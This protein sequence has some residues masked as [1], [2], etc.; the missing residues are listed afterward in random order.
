MTV[1]REGRHPGEFLLSEAAGQRSRGTATIA[2][3]AGVIAAGTVLG[4]DGANYVPATDATDAVAVSI[5]GC[6]A[7]VEDQDIAIIARDAEVKA[8]ALTF[9]ASVDD[10]TKRAAKVTQLA[11]VGILVR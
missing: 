6:D 5:Y 10:D 3:G 2:S 8:D 7:S 4:M 1:F 11:S 9:D